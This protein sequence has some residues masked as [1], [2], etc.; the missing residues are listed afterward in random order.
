MVFSIP[1]WVRGWGFRFYSLFTLRISRFCRVLSLVVGL[2][3]LLF[4]LISSTAGK[5][6]SVMGS[7]TARAAYRLSVSINVTVLVDDLFSGFGIQ[8]ESIRFV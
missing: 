1:C 4:S 7:S 8:L 2:G 5:L 6:D 3:S